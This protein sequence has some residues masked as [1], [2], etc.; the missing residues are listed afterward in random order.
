MR[1]LLECY[2]TQH[3]LKWL[4][5]LLPGKHP[6]KKSDDTENIIGRVNIYEPQHVISNNVAF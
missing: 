1:K 2:Y 6:E 3:E 5:D 4:D